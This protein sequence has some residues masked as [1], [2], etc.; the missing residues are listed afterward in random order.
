MDD[1]VIDLIK[2]YGGA[3][4]KTDFFGFG[5]DAVDKYIATRCKKSGSNSNPLPPR[6]TGYQNQSLSKSS[7]PIV[8]SNSGPNVGRYPTGSKK[9][10]REEKNVSTLRVS[11][12]TSP[13]EDK[14]RTSGKSSPRVETF[15][16]SD[17]L[18]SNANADSEP[19]FLVGEEEEED[20]ENPNNEASEEQTF[21]F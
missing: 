20:D 1:D 4:E 18:P 17:V 3:G 14:L 8:I 10:V 9:S 5:P 2:R 16:K 6:D 19:Q 11:P 13:K 12:P 21:T 7:S 15:S